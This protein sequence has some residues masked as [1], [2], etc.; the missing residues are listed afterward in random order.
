[1]GTKDLWSLTLQWRRKS[2]GSRLEAAE[3]L[4]TGRDGMTYEKGG[5]VIER[6]QEGQYS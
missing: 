3:G 5:Q 4:F 2:R 1:M 6:L